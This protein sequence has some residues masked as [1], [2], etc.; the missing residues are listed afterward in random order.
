MMFYLN[1]VLFSI[2]LRRNLAESK[3]RKK[4]TEQSVAFFPDSQPL[5]GYTFRVCL[6]QTLFIRWLI[7]SVI[8]FRFLLKRLQAL[9]ILTILSLRLL[10]L[11]TLILKSLSCWRPRLDAHFTL[12]T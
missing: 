4:A 7:P 1:V 12:F 3:Q 8:R 5:T 9:V 2:E 10:A 11:L 6:Q